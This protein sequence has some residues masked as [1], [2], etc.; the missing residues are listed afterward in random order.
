MSAKSSAFSLLALVVLVLATNLYG[1]DAMEFFRHTEADR[2]L[3]AWEMAESG[4]YVVPR[5]THSVLLTKPPLYYWILAS[6]IRWTGSVEEWVVRLPSVFAALL[7][8]L[9][10]YLF[11]VRSG[12]SR[13]LALFAAFILATS[14]QLLTI[15]NVAEIDI[16]FGTLSALALFALYLGVVRSSLCFILLAYLGLALALLTK[17]LPILIFFFAVQGL[18]VLHRWYHRVVPVG[19]NL[20][21]LLVANIVGALLL[22]VVV[23]PWLLALD[24]VMGLED[25]WTQTKIEVFDRVVQDV[26]YKRGPLYYFGVLATGFAPWFIGPLLAAGS[27]AKRYSLQQLPARDYGSL[28]DQFITFCLVVVGVVFVSLSLAE[29]KSARY[30]FPLVPFLSCVAAASFQFIWR[31]QNRQLIFGLVRWLGLIVLGGVPIAAYVLGWWMDV[32]LGPIVALGLLGLVFGVLLFLAERKRE[33][34][35]IFGGLAVLAFSYR[36]AER[37][38]FAP[39]RNRDLSVQWVA[40]AIDQELP[41]G[42]RI[43]NLELFDRWLTYYLKRLGRESYRLEPANLPD[44]GAVN[45]RSFVLISG[46]E[47]LWRLDEVRGIDKTSV[48]VRNFSDTRDR[49]ILIEMSSELL[50]RLRYTRMFPTYP[51]LPFFGEVPGAGIEPARGLPPTGF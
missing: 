24:R 39:F 7:L 47:E 9:S 30:I 44:V 34:T 1:L 26:R 22:V 2:T 27:W 48:V 31:G 41:A 35:L 28:F 10:T 13:N 37:E 17:G 16:T 21:F 6:W 5:L 3:I 38:I 15:A 20:V 25:L 29:G 11:A 40:R 19:R 18:F 8:V 12:F 36:V 50:P 51:S 14:G 33:V 46:N 42:A 49:F 43:Y 4:D 32:E 23:G 45:G